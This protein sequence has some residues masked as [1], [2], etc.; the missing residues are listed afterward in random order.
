[1][2][3]TIFRALLGSAGIAALIGV[4]AVTVSP[5]LIGPDSE[6]TPD[7]Q[8]GAKPAAIEMKVAQN[9]DGESGGAKD[10]HEG[11]GHQ[12]KPP[13]SENHN[14]ESEME[15]EGH[16]H[17]KAEQGGSTT[18]SHEGHGHGEKPPDSKNH[19]HESEKDHEGHGHDK[20]G[21]GAV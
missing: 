16:G 5:W 13:A 21:Q 10:S 12:A 4:A 17:D 15:H 19:D 11:H 7:L 2:K 8:P 3:I 6:P 20:T 1:M 18:D 9:A 14:Q